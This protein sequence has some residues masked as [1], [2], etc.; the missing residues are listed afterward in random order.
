M[1]AAAEASFQ[2]SLGSAFQDYCPQNSGP[3]ISSLE[4]IKRS[5]TLGTVPN[6]LQQNSPKESSY[7]AQHDANGVTLTALDSTSP[8]CPPAKKIKHEI[9]S[10]VAKTPP[11]QISTMTPISSKYRR[12]SQ[13]ASDLNSPLSMPSSIE[14]T[15]KNSTKSAQKRTPKNK[16]T[17]EHDGEQNIFT[18]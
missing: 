15:P 17:A 4:S 3:S 12:K 14:K 5:P 7:W 1:M 2:K 6:Y 18:F 11:S 13:F 8:S 10:P 16:T 9:T